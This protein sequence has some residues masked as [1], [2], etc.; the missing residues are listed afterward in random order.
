[1]NGCFA[2][3]SIL[4]Q[5]QQFITDCIEPTAPP[6]GLIKQ[7]AGI[8]CRRYTVLVQDS[9]L[10]NFG[11]FSCMSGWSRLLHTSNRSIDWKE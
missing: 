4:T 7:T 2:R 5:Y 8:G 3:K 6:A 9:R 11:L 1:M 10:P